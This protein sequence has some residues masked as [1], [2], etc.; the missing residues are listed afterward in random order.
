MSLD[1]VR[2]YG[3]LTLL[4]ILPQFVCRWSGRNNREKIGVHVGFEEICP[5]SP[6]AAGDPWSPSDQNVLYDLSAVVMH[7]GKDSAQDTTHCLLLQ[8]WRR[9]RW[10]KVFYLGVGFLEAGVESTQISKLD[11]K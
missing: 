1:Q 10:K 7:H 5:W 6:I 8:F 3:P 11:T 2:G 4:I 9:Y